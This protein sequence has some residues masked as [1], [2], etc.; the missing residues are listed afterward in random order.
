MTVVVSEEEKAEKSGRSLLTV[1]NAAASE[2]ANRI[3][4]ASFGEG[5]MA[6]FSISFEVRVSFE[7]EPTPRSP[8]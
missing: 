5:A 8:G 4:A 1:E 7:V 3:A 2:Q 6:L